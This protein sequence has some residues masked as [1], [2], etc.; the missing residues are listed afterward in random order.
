[1]DLGL[2]GRVALV[3]GAGWRIGLATTRRRA[4]RRWG[5]DREA[6]IDRFVRDVRGMPIGRLGASEDVAAAIVFLAADRAS[7]I[8]GSNCRVDGG[9][10]PTT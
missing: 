6:A 7:Q 2:E 1:M 10:I 9:L 4:G 5:I 8:T 3:T